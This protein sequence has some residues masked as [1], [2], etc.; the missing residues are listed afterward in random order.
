M[1]P[2]A[3]SGYVSLV[4]P[5]LK[6][7]TLEVP[8]WTFRGEPEAGAF[9]AWA[10]PEGDGVGLYLFR[11]PPDLPSGLQSEHAL[12][13][14]YAALAASARGDLVELAVRTVSD[15]RAVQ[16]IVRVPQG[17]SGCTFLGSLMIPYAAF[18]VVAKA[19][20]PERGAFG[21]REAHVLDQRLAAG[22][23]PGKA[24]LHP[25]RDWN[26]YHARYDG[27]FPQHPV[28]RVRAILSR[29]AG[30]LVLDEALRSQPAF[31]LPEPVDELAITRS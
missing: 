14:H 12:A 13:A 21:E 20:C 15:Q 18:S 29:L 6:Q 10:T 7:V 24:Q 5:S 9:R 3:A 2:S 8:E 17:P 4:T 30:S 28:S 25:L 22:E 27:A 23:L 31:D 11:T 19:Q 26:P 16:T 1:A